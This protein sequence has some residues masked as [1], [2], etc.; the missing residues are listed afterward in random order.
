MYLVDMHIAASIWYICKSKKKSAPLSFSLI[1][2]NIKMQIH[3]IP[4]SVFI[5]WYVNPAGR[6]PSYTPYLLYHPGKHHTD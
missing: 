1:A 5:A 3:F 6:Y 4:V 2:H